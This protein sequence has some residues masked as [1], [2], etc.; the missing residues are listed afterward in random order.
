MYVESQPLLSVR[1]CVREELD[2]HT[3]LHRQSHKWI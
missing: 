2:I 1:A 3:S